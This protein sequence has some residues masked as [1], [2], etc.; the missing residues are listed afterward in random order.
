MYVLHGECIAT[1]GR[2]RRHGEKKEN[3]EMGRVVRLSNL[4]SVRG[5]NTM[6]GVL[7]RATVWSG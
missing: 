2:K 7:N 4:R 6:K 1:W 5:V 3:G